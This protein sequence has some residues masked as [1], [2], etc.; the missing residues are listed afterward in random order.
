[1]E[2]LCAASEGG[3]RTDPINKGLKLSLNGR[4]NCWSISSAQGQRASASS[5][6]QLP[7]PAATHQEVLLQEFGPHG[8]QGLLQRSG[9]DIKLFS[10]LLL[11]GLQQ[12]DLESFS[13][14]DTV[15]VV[16]LNSLHL[17]SDFLSCWPP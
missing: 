12:V 7:F 13:V 4:N 10:R 16:V 5:T 11:F 8:P 17:F 15:A 14:G 1:M 9:F 6:K 3:V 2:S